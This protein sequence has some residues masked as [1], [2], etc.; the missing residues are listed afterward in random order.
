MLRALLFLLVIVPLWG[1]LHW[2]IGTRLIS[3]ARPPKVL[4]ILG[5]SVIVFNACLGP[6]IMGGRRLGM[7]W[8]AFEPFVTMAYLGM[9][10]FSLFLILVLARDA[11]VVVYDLVQRVRTG[12]SKKE[13]VR[14]DASPGLSRRELF[15]SATSAG[16]ATLGVAASAKGYHN[17][18][19][20]PDVKRVQV[21]LAPAHRG[22]DG[23]RIVQISDV[24][25]G[26]TIGPD[27]L[28]AVVDRVNSLTPDVVAITGDLV[29]GYPDTM[30]QGVSALSRIKATHGVF[31]V[32]GNHEYY[33]DGPGW[34]KAVEGF[35]VR[36][37]VNAHE[38]LEHNGHPFVVA[39]VTDYSAGRMSPEHTT[40][41]HKA[42]EGAPD[43]F[44][45]ML[46][47]QPKSVWE[48]SKA[49][50]T[51]QL[52]GHTHGGQF[53]PWNFVVGRVHP[54]ARGLHPYED[55]HI[56]VSCGT[57]FWGPPMR[58]GA[59][60]EIT[61]LTLNAQGSEERR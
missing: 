32:T 25:V 52:S 61:L 23:L 55:M 51:L 16:I 33:W 18:T 4:K 20:L 57:G 11:G 53:Y 1:G 8:V 15:T 38:V 26:N 45:L 37:L 10:A 3:H 54:F 22:L 50:A 39:G 40:D 2:Y 43:V 48:A 44:R 58:L 29:D 13:R 56:Y 30:G 21:P 35:G 31:F 49:G 17:A 19:R 36:A 28:E 9:G 46:A 24:H 6:V 59:P 5:W 12:T 60:S 47:H 27:F 7:E 42:L 14:Q 41:P 34:V